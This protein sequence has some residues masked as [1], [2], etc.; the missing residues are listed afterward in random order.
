MGI[1][2]HTSILLSQVDHVQQHI[3]GSETSRSR[4]SILTFPD[5]LHTGRDNGACAAGLATL[6][7]KAQLNKAPRSWASI[8]D[9]PVSVA[10][11]M[12]VLTRSAMVLRIS[13]EV[14]S[15]ALWGQTDRLCAE[16]AF[17][18]ENGRPGAWQ[19]G[20]GL[21]WGRLRKKSPCLSPAIN[22]VSLSF[23]FLHPLNPLLSPFAKMEER[24]G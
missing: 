15:T 9:F 22:P 16:S 8:S 17:R 20:Q 3:Q 18:R 6:G 4:A 24:G 23:S 1:P 2:G 21:K 10:K 19:G 5:S 7:L 12:V 11:R 13:I 14:K